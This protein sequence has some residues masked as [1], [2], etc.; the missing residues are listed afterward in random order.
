MKP[1]QED[2]TENRHGGN[3]QSAA[4]FEKIVK[5]LPSMRRIVFDAIAHA[6]KE[7][8][9]CKELARAW[10]CG[11]NEIS[12]RF[13]ELKR[14]KRIHRIATREGSGVMVVSQPQS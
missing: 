8:L 13:T 1:P 5:S 6:G 7:G 14:D 4:A 12:G 9:T 11:M 3:E 10:G 2:I